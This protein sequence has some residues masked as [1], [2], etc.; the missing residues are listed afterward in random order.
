MRVEP[1]NLARRIE[2]QVFSPDILADQIVPAVVV[3]RSCRSPWAEPKA[4]RIEPLVAET[5]GRPEPEG[6]ELLVREGRI[7]GVAGQR[8]FVVAFA[9]APLARADDMIDILR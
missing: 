9:R 8:A 2:G 3:K 5:A 7:A 1:G 4:W 6:F